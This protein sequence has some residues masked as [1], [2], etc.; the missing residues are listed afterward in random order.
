MYEYFYKGYKAAVYS[1]E[2]EKAPSPILMPFESTLIEA[3]LRD[4]NY[5]F[6]DD[7]KTTEKE[8]RKDIIVKSFKEVVKKM[9]VA[10]KEGKL[11]WAN[12]ESPS[13]NHLLK[14][15]P[16]SRMNLVTGGGRNDINATNVRKGDNGSATHGPS[17]RMVISLTANTEAYGIYPGGQNGNPGSK[18]YDQ[19]VDKWAASEYYNLWM[20]KKDE[21]KDNRV[22]YT[23]T[24]SN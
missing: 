13:I 21:A 20:M 5:I 8:T 17:W 12:S 23:M 1:D 2:Y 15:G 7:I 24:F 22:K 3:S 4:S 9:I 10:E 11:V 18:Y 19:F 16:F 6:F 14:I